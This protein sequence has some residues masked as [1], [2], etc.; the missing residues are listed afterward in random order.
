M[1]IE[2][3]IKTYCSQGGGFRANCKQFY[4]DR[5]VKDNIADIRAV[6]THGCSGSARL[7]TLPEGEWEEN[8]IAIADFCWELY[9]TLRT[10]HW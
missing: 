10:L 6:V 7:A 1:D 2:Q 5:A 9:N 8:R 3:F 4:R